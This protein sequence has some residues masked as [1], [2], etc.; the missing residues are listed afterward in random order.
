M[1]QCEIWYANLNP[2]KGSEQQGLR[3]VV[4]I[5]GDLLNQ[6]LPVVITCP[7]TTKIKD[8]KGNVILEPN[9]ING[10]SEKSEIVVFQIRSISKD[11]LVNKIGRI[12]EVQLQQLKQGLDDILRY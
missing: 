3:P 6:Y 9:E 5:S 2:G 10:L 11:R 4:I 8:Y 7:L 1:K 12:K